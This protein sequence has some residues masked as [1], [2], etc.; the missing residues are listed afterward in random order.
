MLTTQELHALRAL[1]TMILALVSGCATSVAY[2]PP[3]REYGYRPSAISLT[4]MNGFAAAVYPLP[5]ERPEGELRVVSFGFTAMQAAHGAPSFPTLHVRVIASNNGD[6]TVWRLDTRQ[7]LLAVP[8]LGDVAALYVNSDQ[9]SMPLL[10]VPRGERRTVDF[11]FPLPRPVTAPDGLPGFDL[12]WQ[13]QTGTRLVAERT[14]FQR[15]ELPRA[16][17]MQPA[18]E[19]V[20]G[21]GPFWWFPPPHGL[22]LHGPV[23]AVSHRH[24]PV[25]IT[26]HARGLRLAR[27]WRR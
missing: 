6:P 19:L 5:P 13:V 2:A 20:I 7:V 25:V 23:V 27:P 8:G 16:I 21:W 22:Y 14:M 4:D 18:T 17:P 1:V 15:V 12:R 9:G 3:E 26:H 11:Y 10:S 24:P